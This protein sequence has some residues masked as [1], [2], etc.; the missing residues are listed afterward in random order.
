MTQDGT[1]TAR[2]D[3]S[4]AY[5]GDVFFNVTSKK[6]SGNVY[7]ITVS[8]VTENFNN[9]VTIMSYWSEFIRINNNNSVVKQNISNSVINSDGSVTFDFTVPTTN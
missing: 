8:P 7:T 6:K 4:G 9:A 2:T 3:G 1:F 5:T